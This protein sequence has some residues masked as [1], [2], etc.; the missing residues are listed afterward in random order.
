MPKDDHNLDEF[1]KQ[2]AEWDQGIQALHDG[3]K[4]AAAMYRGLTGEGVTGF[5]AAVAVG[6]A[7]Q[8]VYLNADEQEGE[9]G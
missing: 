2:A 1:A 8:A 4:M 6:T 7:L 5:H 9:D 3:G